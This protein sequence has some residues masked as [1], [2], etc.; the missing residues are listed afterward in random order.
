[1]TSSATSVYN[2]ELFGGPKDGEK[3]ELPEI[4][5]RLTYKADRNGTWFLLYVKR[6]GARATARGVVFGYDF[7]G[8]I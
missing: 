6:S 4:P 3:L 5:M 8:W 2:V 1:M 7:D